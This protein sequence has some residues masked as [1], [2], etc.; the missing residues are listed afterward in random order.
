MRSSEKKLHTSEIDMAIAMLGHV[1]VTVLKA[2]DVLYK[3]V[4]YVEVSLM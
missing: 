3:L 4:T 2:L 1:R